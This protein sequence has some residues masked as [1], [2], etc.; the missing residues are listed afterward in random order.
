MQAVK[1]EYTVRPEY[2]EQNKANIGKVMDYLRENPI[3]GMQYSTFIKEDGQSFV[4]INMAR[5]GEI[6]S[7][8]N[9]VEAFQNFRKGLKG[10][11]PL[12]SPSATKL[13]FVGA[14]FEI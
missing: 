3:E 9:D 13:T 10:S 12:S 5:S 1:V 8:L 4:H 2:V 7:K 11:Q 6:I 14:G